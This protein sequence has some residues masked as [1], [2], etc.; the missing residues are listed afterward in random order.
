LQNHNIDNF[1]FLSPQN[2]SKNIKL[3]L[4]RI[5]K[6]LIKINNPCKKT[7]AIQIIGTNG[8]GSITA[9]LESIL[10][11]SNKKIGVTTSPHL[12]DIYERI[13]VNKKFISKEEFNNLF[14]NLG[15]QLK[16][17]ELS[18][19]EFI[20]CCALK[21]FD[22]EKVDLLLL[23]AGLGG[24]YDA[25]SA[26]K[27]RPIIAIGKIGIDHSNYL[28]NT[29]EKITQ[30][31][32][33]VIQENSF[34]ISCKQHTAV[35]SLINK[36]INDVK[37]KII[38]VDELSENW[39]LGLKGNFQR[40]NAAVALGVIKVLNKLGWAIKKSSIEEGLAKTE[41]PGRLQLITWKNK[42]ILIDSAHNPSAAEVLS[43]ERENWANQ[44]EGV[45]WILG[46][47]KQKDIFSIIGNIL[48]ARDKI[49]LVPIPNQQCWTLDEILKSSDMYKGIISEF[50]DF[51]L[52][53]N[54][55]EK[56]K[57]WPSCHPV[58]TGSIYLISDFM[59]SYKFSV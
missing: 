44:E 39:K 17:F 49:L 52:A 42:K 3:G 36:K 40:E 13:R 59:R 29:L 10:S 5:E 50:D 2:E 56:L 4:K 51:N 25:T 47:Q 53:L 8:K 12:F 19:F 37:A 11:T 6:A 7:P 21:F 23:E 24:R 15:K 57:E 43:K 30:E 41:W 26:H 14:I 55:L 58:L 46:V 33:A 9:F 32:I 18:P 20:I 1:D 31:K 34:V 45:Y 22:Q 48:K 28:G 38:W 16:I 35:E 54:Y 27:L